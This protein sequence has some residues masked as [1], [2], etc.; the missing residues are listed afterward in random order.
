MKKILFI[1]LIMVMILTSCNLPTSNATPSVDIIATRVAGTMAA[2]QT[3]AAIQQPTNA[4]PT[5]AFETATPEATA[6]STITP[7]VTPPLNDPKLTLG[8]P[9]FTFNS[10]SSGN[11]FGLAGK[12]YEDDSILI[13]HQ[14][15]GITF[16]SKGVNGGK[17]W[18]L[19]APTPTNF[20][21]EGTFKVVTCSGHDNYGL[22]M[23]V[24]SYESTLGYFVGLSCDGSYIVDK[25]DAAGNAENMISWTP[26]NHIKTGEGQINRLGVMLVNDSFKVYINGELAK[27]F[28]DGTIKT[29]GHGGAYISARDNSHFTVELQELLEWDQ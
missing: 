4:L 7:T 11:P 13:S 14:V 10:A 3:A 6:T 22:T 19:S 18:R 28:T 8:S 29:P 9:D 5:V 23:R 26:D 24:P 12:P 27:E 21:L 20:Y 25:I 1:T 2:S 15:G 16:S 17:R